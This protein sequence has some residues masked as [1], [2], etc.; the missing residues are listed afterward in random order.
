M[1]TNDSIIKNN[2]HKRNKIFFLPEKEN[3]TTLMKSYLQNK[4]IKQIKQI[5]TRYSSSLTSTFLNESATVKSLNSKYL[6]IRKGMRSIKDQRKSYVNNFYSAY[7]SSEKQKYTNNNGK[8]SKI[9]LKTEKTKE[10]SERI[11]LNSYFPRINRS[12]F[13]SKTQIEHERKEVF[14]LNFIKSIFSNKKNEEIKKIHDKYMSFIRIS[15]EIKR[16]KGLITEYFSIFDR[17]ST[18]IL[19]LRQKERK[20]LNKKERLDVTLK[21]KIEKLKNYL[22]K[23]KVKLNMINNYKEFILYVKFKT[24]DSNKLNKLNDFILLKSLSLETKKGKVKIKENNINNINNNINSTRN[25]NNSSIGNRKQ[26]KVTSNLSQSLSQSLSPEDFYNE[27]KNIQDKII[28]LLK[29]RTENSNQIYFLTKTNQNLIKNQKEKKEKSKTQFES[30]NQ[31]N[32]SYLKGI[33]LKK[34]EINKEFELNFTLINEN[35]DEEYRKIR[36]CNEFIRYFVDNYQI[37]NENIKIIRK[38][39]FKVIDKKIIKYSPE[40]SLLSKKEF[41]YNISQIMNIIISVNKDFTS[42]LLNI[43]Y[44]K[45]EKIIEKLKNYLKFS[46]FDLNLFEFSEILFDSFLFLYDFLNFN[47]Q[48]LYNTCMKR[49]SNENKKIDNFLSKLIIFDK[50]LRQINRI[51]G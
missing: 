19:S 34:H 20:K 36:N 45:Q 48:I 18:C 43:S 44:E 47:N 41:L 12:N 10:E 50:N 2:R 28:T 13:V 23:L 6:I 9:Y 46:K 27:M 16:I 33:S 5:K 38:F 40:F 22:Q 15:Y 17:I 42:T 4:P 32:D 49:M 11:L 35:V 29:K 24:V 26:S 37:Y 21:L 14:R 7:K 8:E 1:I 25:I 30:Y 31:M 51:R 39:I 3:Q